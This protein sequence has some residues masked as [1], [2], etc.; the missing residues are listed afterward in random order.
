M[1][2][3]NIGL[4]NFSHHNFHGEWEQAFGDTNPFDSQLLKRVQPN[5]LCVDRL[6][7]KSSCSVGFVSVKMLNEASVRLINLA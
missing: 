6:L 1:K 3:A 2:I 5:T 7:M 4:F